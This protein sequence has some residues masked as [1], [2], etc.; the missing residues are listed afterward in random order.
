M[1][2]IWAVVGG[3]L[4][5]CS[6]RKELGGHDPVNISTY[7]VSFYLICPEFVTSLGDDSGYSGLGWVRVWLRATE[8]TGVSYIV[9]VYEYVPRIMGNFSQSFGTAMDGLPPHR[10]NVPNFQFFSQYLR[11]TA[12]VPVNFEIKIPPPGTERLVRLSVQSWPINEHAACSQFKNTQTWHV[13]PVVCQRNI[14]CLYL[15]P[16]NSVF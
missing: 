13:A 8:S 1:C 15:S 2:L 6:L 12:R 16:C 5:L 7:D 3:N 11:G 4:L 14:Y 10:P 9:T